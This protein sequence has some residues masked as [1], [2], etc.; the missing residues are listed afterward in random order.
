MKTPQIKR[1]GCFI[2]LPSGARSL[3]R[4]I[5][6]IDPLD[7]CEAFAGGK[8]IE[9]KVIEPRVVVSFGGHTEIIYVASHEKAKR[10]AA[11]LSRLVNE[12]RKEAV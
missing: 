10:M 5:T 1:D 7:R 8:V 12:M 9:G 4:H 3:P 11:R 6:T 2:R